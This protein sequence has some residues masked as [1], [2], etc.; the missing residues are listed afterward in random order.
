MPLWVQLIK[1][2]GIQSLI[3]LTV[4]ISWF[5]VYFIVDDYMLPELTESPSQVRR[6]KIS[7]T[8]EQTD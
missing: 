6:S 7:A 1:T 5:I 8:V 2:K 4:R 3:A